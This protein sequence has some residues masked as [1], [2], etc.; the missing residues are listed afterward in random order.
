MVLKRPDLQPCDHCSIHYMYWRSAL[1]PHAQFQHH[2]DPT[3]TKR[4]KRIIIDLSVKKLRLV[5][6]QLIFSKILILPSTLPRN[7]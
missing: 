2:W 1:D 3:S 5:K 6:G 7:V 4:L